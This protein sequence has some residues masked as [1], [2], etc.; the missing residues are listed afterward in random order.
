MSRPYEAGLDAVQFADKTGLGMGVSSAGHAKLAYDGV[1]DEVVASKNGATFTSLLGPLTETPATNATATGV[2]ATMTAGEN[3]VF[4]D[5]CYFQSDQKWRKA[6]ANAVG[7]YPAAAMALGTI[8][9]GNTGSFLFFGIARLDS[10]A[11]TAGGVLYLSI[12]AG[13]MTQTQPAAANDVIQ[14]LG[15]ATHP[16]RVFFRPDLT[17]ITHV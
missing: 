15:I 4:G 11:W 1:L 14:V 7:L 9:A 10:W 2:K 16:D 3:V 12:T 5:V 6:D 13:G 8:T 17:Y